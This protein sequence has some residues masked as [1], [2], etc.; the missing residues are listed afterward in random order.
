M[1]HRDPVVDGDRVELTRDPAG[2]RDALGDDLADGLQMR[3][4]GDELGVGVGDGDDRLAEVLARDAG[5]SQQG[6]GAGHVAAMGDGARP[7]FWHATAGYT[8]AAV[9][10]VRGAD[11]SHQRL[12][13]VTQDLLRELRVVDRAGDEQRADERRQRR[14]RA[15]DGRGA[16]SVPSSSSRRAR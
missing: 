8:A 9:S 14:G 1:A 3:V 2:R 11:G 5:G 15:A 7:E 4:A 13:R 12:P 16:P 6:S 10:A